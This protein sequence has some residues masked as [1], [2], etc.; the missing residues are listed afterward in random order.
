MKNRILLTIV[1]MV[2]LPTALLSLMAGRAVRNRELVILEQMK[3]N[4]ESMT[5][6]CSE[7]V[8][9]GIKDELNR[10]RETIGAVLMRTASA[11][12]LARSAEVLEQSSPLI[13]KV[14]VY[15]DPWDVVYP[16]NIR[17]ESTDPD[18]PSFVEHMRTEIALIKNSH[19]VVSLNDD[20]VYYCFTLIPA[21]KDLYAGFRVDLI[22]LRNM[23]DR[24]LNKLTTDE[25]LLVAEG[26]MYRPDNAVI[27]EDPF[28]SPAPIQESVEPRISA[29]PLAQ[30]ACAKPFTDITVSA[31]LRHPAQL[32]RAGQN[33]GKLMAWGIA[34]L[35]GGI[36]AGVLILIFQIHEEIRRTSARANYII[37]ISHDLRTPIASLKMMTESLHSGTVK[38]PDKQHI[39]LGTMAGECERLNR[40]V[41][42]VLYFV[43]YGEDALV[44]FKKTLVVEPLLNDIA[45]PFFESA[46]GNRH[47][48]DYSIT[49]ENNIPEIEADDNAISQIILNLLDNALK[50]GTT[51]DNRKPS[52]TISAELV[53][54]RRNSI[55]P[56]R[57]WVKISVSDTGPGIREADRRKIFRPYFRSSSALNANISGVGLG[58]ALCRHIAR[59]HDGWMEAG[60]SKSGGAVF[61]LFLPC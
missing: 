56:L 46:A 28:A 21:R 27:I 17:A 29:K 35:A 50:Y 53:E 36:L 15:H 55:R 33:Q 18:Q 52:I 32:Q 47:Q 8:E 6:L 40:L 19:T 43:R 44:F 31:Y 2:I 39:F 3:N 38:D 60:N 48:V 49:V 10:I 5:R 30:A 58:L 22:G 61:S 57:R 24:A 4:A 9:A 25:I 11:A 13:D 23:L 1:A 54:R 7:E 45:K 37:G 12:E 20:G 51:N 26:R 41:E 42:R 34:L 59:A 16:P 14:V